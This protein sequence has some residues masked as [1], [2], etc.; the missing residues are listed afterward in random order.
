M[1]NK[2]HMVFWITFILLCVNTVYADVR[3]NIAVSNYTIKEKVVN[4]GKEFILSLTLIN[5]EPSTCAKSI[6]T[7]IDSGFPFI[8][9][10]VSTLSIG[11][12]CSGNTKVVDYPLKVDPTAAGGFYQ[13]NVVS[14]Y[15]S[16]TYIQ[17]SSTSAINLFVNGSP[18]IN[19]NIINSQP[20]DIYPGDIGTLSVKI[21]N[22]GNFQA[23]SVSASM[24]AVKPIEVKWSQSFNTVEVLD[25]KQSKTIDFIVEV[26][27]DAEAKYYQITLDLTYLDE[28]RV[29]QTKT[30]EFNLYIK[31]KAQFETS[32]AGSDNLYA[33]QDLRKV[34]IFLRDTGTDDARKV[35]VRV[36]PQFPFSTDGSVRYIEFLGAG[37]SE[38][39]DF[40]VDIDKDA[41]PGNYVLDML[42]DY[43][44]AQGKKLQDTTQLGLVVKP[45][46]ITRAVFID[47][48]VLWIITI[49]IVSI[50]V[51]RRYSGHKK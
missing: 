37:K 24:K 27:R 45:K 41:T 51:R 17:F 3:P 30:F 48:W 8:M 21:E 44:D 9:E 22:N 28:N 10:G 38:P 23:Q 18:E 25:P 50:I 19:A 46:G 7:S 5:T 29:K 39:I 26:P 4:V 12:L 34:K 15:E 14:N 33:N 47:Y 2:I 49:I 31:K 32:D 35:R 1:K 13:I 42:V 40:N 11:N 20:I 43:E 6:T 36:L 16:A